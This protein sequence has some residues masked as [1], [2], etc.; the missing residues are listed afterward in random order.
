VHWAFDDVP[1]P[2]NEIFS[3]PPAYVS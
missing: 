2:A 3:V 1:T